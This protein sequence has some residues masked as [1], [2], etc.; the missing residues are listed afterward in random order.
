MFVTATL[1]G[2]A[3]AL[4]YFAWQAIVAI[5]F[6]LFFAYLLEPLV[7]LIERRV[8]RSHM[9]AIAVSYLVFAGLLAGAFF[10]LGSKVSRE[11]G[12]IAHNGPQ[13]WQQIRNGQMP[14]QMAA[15]G[16]FAGKVQQQLVTWAARNQGKI[17]QFAHQAARYGLYLGIGLF[18]CVVV[19]VLGIFVLKDKDRWI[20][21]LSCEPDA[22]ANRRRM[23]RMLVESDKALARY[24]WAQVLLTLIAFGVFAIVLSVLHLPFALLLAAVQGIGEFVFVFG[25]LAAGVIILAAALFSGKSLVAVFGFLVAWR[26]VQDYVNTPLLF[27]KRLEMHPLVVVVVLM[28]GWSIG[29]V[30]GMFLAVPIAA[31]A[32]IIWETWTA[33][34]DPAKDVADLFRAPEAA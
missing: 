7:K 17:E 25:P 11:A 31:V 10:L 13:Y 14:P 3:L 4:V 30:V 29:N 24:I 23:H 16:G 27:G 12:S 15:Q 9:G 21:S 19:L 34:G 26:I 22:P 8:W 2:I 5:L 28:I 32:Q 20:K 33:N 1:Y 6:A 18:W